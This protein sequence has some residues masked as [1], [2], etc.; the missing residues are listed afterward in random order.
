M[1][2]TKTTREQ[3][4]RGRGRFASELTEGEWAQLEPL[5]PPPHR[6]GRPRKRSLRPIVEAILYIAWTGVQWRA[7]PR[8]F[9][10]FATVQ[11]YFY[12]WRNN[13]LLQKIVGVLVRRTRRALGRADE[14][15]AAVIDSQ[16]APTSHGGPRG[17]DAGKR[18]RGR[19]RHIVTDTNGLM[20]AVDVHPANIQ[21]C[22]GA[23][24]LLTRLRQIYPD[25]QHVF[26]DR[27]YRGKQ[28]RDAIAA[29]GPWSIEI[30]ERVKGQKGFQLLPRRWVVERT[31]AWL[32]GSRRLARDFERS[33]E[34]EAAWILIAHMRILSRRLAVPNAL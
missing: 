27:V 9:P 4:Q 17:Y 29:C 7:L 31:F 21:D 22:H 8:E 14:P 33:A 5:L 34:S 18:V 13:G 15:T 1:P 2:W 19:K 6:L 28:L 30:I 3:Y 23:V 26:A 11:N 12:A 24:P 10:P 25:L 32:A 20:L 16:S